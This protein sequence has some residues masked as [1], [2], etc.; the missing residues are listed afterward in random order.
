MRKRLAAA[1]G[2]AAT[3]A[4]S[5]VVA[6]GAASA[7]AVDP[8]TYTTSLDPG[9]SVTI[10]KTVQ[11]PPIAPTPDIYFLSDST[12]SMGPAIGNVQ[13]NAGTIL[14]TIQGS[15]TDPMFGAGDYK[16][17]QSPTQYD[18]YAFQN[19]A[20]IGSAAGALAGIGTWA[21]GGGYDGPESQLYALHRI[22]TD[23]GIGWRAGATHIL[24]WFGDA[25]GHDPV[26]NALTGIGYDLTTAVVANELKAAGIEV[27]AISLNTGGY[28]AGLNDDSTYDAFDYNAAC[29]TPSPVTGEASTIVGVTGGLDLFAAD[30]NDVASEILAGLTNLPATVAMGTPTCDA[31]LSVS[32]DPASQTVTSG[33]TASFQETISVASDATQGADLACSV[34]FTINGSD[35]GPDYVETVTVH[36]NDVTPPSAACVQ[37]TNP[38][39]DNV[40]AAGSGT[41]NSGQNPDGFYQMVF[42]DNV[43]G[44]TAMLVDSASS[45]SVAVA[46]GEKDKLVQAPGAVPN[47]KPG[48]GDITKKVTTNGDAQLVVTDAAGNVSTAWCRV[49]PPAK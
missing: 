36:V 4:L 21:A 8:A 11:T 35:A 32:L 16:D 27:I 12:G 5:L 10:A 2:V 43:P 48:S 26:C 28:A 23:P 7:A 44:A 22:A 17:F 33:D 40:P 31:G 45:F 41:G 25:P 39:G 20:S 6:V 49:A 19:D 37:T 14:S 13:A 15:A 46:N 3:A 29:G 42:S 47:W 9:G 24:V 18:P 1:A 38:S 30:P 34:P